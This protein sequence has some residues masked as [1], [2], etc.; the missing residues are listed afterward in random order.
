MKRYVKLDVEAFL[1]DS[2]KWDAEIKDLE[3][4]KDEIVILSGISNSEVHSGNISHPTEDTALRYQAI[5][6]EI[7]R[8]HN[9]R[10]ILAE[11]LDWIDADDEALI[12][13]FFFGKKTI[14]AFVDEYCIEHGCEVKTVYRRRAEAVNRLRKAI[15]DII[16][17]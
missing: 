12:N 5:T 17:A 13:G 1:K 2:K 6:E 16:E 9:Y 14:N 15:E 10:D 7:E 8:I 3:K 11:A 4:K